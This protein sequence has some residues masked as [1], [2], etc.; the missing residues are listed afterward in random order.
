MPAD[1]PPA[2]AESQL[3]PWTS[4]AYKASSSFVPLLTS[5]VTQWLSP[6][7]YEHIL[8][9][10]CGD[11]VLTATLKPRCAHITAIDAS[12]NLIAAA[13]RDCRNVQGI[14]WILKDCTQL[15]DFASPP[16][17]TLDENAGSTGKQGFDQVFSN[18][19]LHWILRN[20][21]TRLSTLRNAH[22]LLRPGGTFVFEMGGPAN[23]SDVHIALLSAVSH[24]GVPLTKAKEACP[25][26]FPSEVEMKGLLEQVGFTVERIETEH[27][28]TR[29]TEGVE[30][31]GVEGWVRLHGDA[32]LKAVSP[33]ERDA[34]VREVCDILEIVINRERGEGGLWLGYVRLRVLARKSKE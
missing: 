20:D 24:H 33:Q 34:V 27:R 12:P 11:G 5:K 18:A 19:A 17:S 9:L 3:D 28:P 21:A 22:R 6:K 15:E 30:G 31:G 16:A 2:D 4:K 25:W 26:Y 14:E 10:G 32:F 13:K 29:L 23:A 7:P 8:D 1:P